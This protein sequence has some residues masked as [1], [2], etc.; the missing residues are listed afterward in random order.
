MSAND[1]NILTLIDKFSE[2]LLLLSEHSS[3]H[4][5]TH[6]SERKRIKN[7]A[8]EIASNEGINQEIDDLMQYL[9]P[10]ENYALHSLAVEELNLRR[11]TLMQFN[12]YFVYSF[13]LF[14]KF[15]SDV[16]KLSVTKNKKVRELYAQ[17]FLN[18]AKEHRSKNNDDK[19]I[20]MLTDWKKMLANYDELPNPI[21]I[22]I[23]IF[24]VNE[25]GKI[26]EK[27]KFKYVE[28]RERRNLLT[29]R[30]QYIDKRYLDSIKRGLGKNG[31]QY[32]KRLKKEVFRS[33]EL[34]FNE[35]EKNRIPANITPSY[36]VS[37][38]ET[39]LYIAIVIHL[40]AF[41][42]SKKLYR[43]Q[44]S[45]ALNAC[46]R[47]LSY[48]FDFKS[49]TFLFVCK[50]IWFYFA[51]EIANLDIKDWC[52]FERVNYCLCQQ[53]IVEILNPILEESSAHSGKKLTAFKPPNFE[54]ILEYCVENEVNHRNLA[55]AHFRDKPK[56]ILKYCEKIPV[57]KVDFHNWVIFK[58]W[59][60]NPDLRTFFEHSS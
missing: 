42:K 21:A 12:A 56:E 15:I 24:G 37:V 13:T 59:Q 25:S 53:K 18:F 57:T 58:K 45:Y 7:F 55:L 34:N 19:Y 23:F 47:I 8:D 6:V 3:Q 32:E 41:K 1:K 39:L 26:F 11:T 20:N 54:K 50:D 2:D 36:F 33:D 51:K 17:Q 9:N 49:P 35:L 27:R 5:K 52:L 14:E 43:E 60:D 48:A 40:A 31:Q 22:A 44:G 4:I 16:I 10:H 29:H 46:H 28:A 30:G 38:I